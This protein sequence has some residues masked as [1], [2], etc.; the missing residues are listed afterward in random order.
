MKRYIDGN[1]RMKMKYDDNTVWLQFVMFVIYI[2]ITTTFMLIGILGLFLYVV[3]VPPN[4]FYPGYNS[5]IQDKYR[6][7]KETN[8]P[9]I[10]ICSGSSSAFGLNQ[11]MLEIETG[12]K[13]ANLGVHAGFGQAFMTELSKANINEGDIVLL[14]F[15]YNW[16]GW[17]KDED[18][19]QKK[20]C[21]MYTIDPELIMTG[22]DS[23]VEMYFKLPLWMWDDLIG[24]IFSF[25]RIKSGYQ[26]ASGVY[27]RESFDLQTGQMTIYRPETAEDMYEISSQAF[28]DL[29]VNGVEH[30]DDRSIR[31]LRKYK[32]FVEKHGA[33]L[34]FTMPPIYEGN[35][36]FSYDEFD[37]LMDEAVERTGIE[38]ISIQRDYI[39]PGKLMYNATCHCN[40]EGEKVRTQLLIRDIKN[41][42]IID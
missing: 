35:V 23:D 42:G 20:I 4:K 25:V 13:V 37:R 36:K 6:V 7:L 26:G 21:N 31:Y 22:V 24:E 18:S 33:K 2:F 16:M 27:S 39:F 8:A 34:Y 40:S 29:V 14:G 41:A 28:K 3:M 19:S 38:S 15:E 17:A 9:K 5:I 10:I 1:T 12:Y 32:R 11:E 30:I